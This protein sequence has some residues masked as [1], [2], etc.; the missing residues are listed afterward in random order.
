VRIHRARASE[1][2]DRVDDMERMAQLG[3]GLWSCE[4]WVLQ[5]STSVCGEAEDERR[6]S[7]VEWWE[8]SA[9]KHAI[10]EEASEV[11]LRT[12][13]ASVDEKAELLRSGDVVAPEDSKACAV[14]EWEEA[15]IGELYALEWRDGVE[16]AEH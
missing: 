13:T 1:S 6:A 5:A 15:D 4:G 14:P 12:L 9:F 16:G 10:A 7:A 2:D 8:S 11:E 3:T